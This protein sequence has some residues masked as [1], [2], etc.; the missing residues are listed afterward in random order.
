MVI[1]YDN[2]WKLL[3]NE[4]YTKTQLCREANITTNAMARLGRNQDVRLET[5]AKICCVLNCT[6]NDI[7]EIIS[8]E[9]QEDLQ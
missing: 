3:L 4:G 5:L 6:L 2:L 7:V 9:E 8:D 1:R